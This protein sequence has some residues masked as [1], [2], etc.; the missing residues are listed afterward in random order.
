MKLNLVADYEV[1][2]KRFASLFQIDGSVNLVNLPEMTKMPFHFSDG[3]CVYLDP[4]SLLMCETR[5]KAERVY[6]MWTDG[7]KKDG[8]FCDSSPLFYD[9][10][11]A[12]QKEK[13]VQA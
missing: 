7:Y 1:M 2:G 9:E 13:G 10:Y 12:Y 5:R 8:R 3:G 11:V 6:R 4:V